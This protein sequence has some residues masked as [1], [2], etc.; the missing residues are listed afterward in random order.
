MLIGLLLIASLNSFASVKN[1]LRSELIA[2]HQ[3]IT[4]K[5]ANEIL[6]TKLSTPDQQ[7]CSVYSPS[8]CL[9]F[10]SIPHHTIMNI[11]HTWPQS[12]GAHGIAK[13]DLH[14][15][16]P[17]TSSSNAR[18]GSFPFCDVSVVQWEEDGSKLGFN[19][20]GEHCFE[21]PAAHKGNVARALF[22]FATRYDFSIDE[23]Q[24]M[25]LRKWNS[26]D[27][28]DAAELLRNSE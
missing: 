8:F 16:F 12:L 25:Y 9:A 4:Y 1:E 18:R 17:A 19:E 13:S 23:H 5:Q 24:E 11:E 20:F 15:L 3:P 6:F 27:L 21:P 26:E 28:I 22:Y 14:H 10:G 7:T 2:N